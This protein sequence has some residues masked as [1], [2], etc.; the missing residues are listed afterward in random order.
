M[1]NKITFKKA[2]NLALSNAMKK[3]KD[4]LI[5]GLGVGDPKNI[6]NTT[7]GLK[8]KFGSYLRNL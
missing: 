2:I 7:S 3:D 6:F 8:E 5:M 4:V 1:K